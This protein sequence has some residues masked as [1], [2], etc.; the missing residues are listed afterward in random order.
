MRRLLLATVLLALSTCA[1]PAP[2]QPGAHVPAH[3]TISLTRGDRSFSVEIWYPAASDTAASNEPIES[4]AVREIDRT[5]YAGLLAKSPASC[6]SRTLHAARDAVPAEGTFPLLVFSHCHE[7]TRFSSASLAEHLASHG[8]AVAAPDHAGNTLFDALDG[9]PLPL[10]SSTLRLRA[11]DVKAV[12]DALLDPASASVPE[13]LRGRFD[14]SKIGVYGHSFGSVTTGLV[15]QEDVRVKAAAGLAAPMENVF[16]PGVSIAALKVPLLF[17][18]AAE[19]NSITELG[20]A[21]I[22]DN[23]EKSPGAAW[24]V[25]IAEAGHWSFSDVAGLNEGFMPGCGSAKRQTDPSKVFSYL[26]APEGVAIARAELAAFFKA[27][28]LGDAKAR[29]WLDAARTD[30]RVTVES[31]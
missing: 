10:D 30:A 3:R 20:N 2:D 5:R 14:G 7:C 11:D 27:Q 1:A 12:L 16:L 21:N 24:K 13:P 17:L 6:A 18:V 19:D 31:K 8:F 25:E 23:F 29:E 15:A 9:T 28:L 26:P 22:R 4:Y